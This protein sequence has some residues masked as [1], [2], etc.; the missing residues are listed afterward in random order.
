MFLVANGRYYYA[1]G[2]FGVL[3]AAAA[4][5]LES[6]EPARWWRWVPTWPV[7]VLSALYSLPYTLPV[8]PAQFLVDHPEAPRPAYAAE[9]VGWPDFAD[10][11]A[12]RTAPRRRA[13]SL[14]TAGY[15]QAGALGRYGPGRG[16]PEAD[17]PS[18]GFWYFGRPDDK[19]TTCCSSGND[20]SKAAKYFR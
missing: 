5:H 1:A 9:E 6:R 16:L 13:P 7:F 2:M 8:W 17:S 14:V 18:R 3:W 12:R 15:W 11:V 20:P 4:V 19:W 10:D